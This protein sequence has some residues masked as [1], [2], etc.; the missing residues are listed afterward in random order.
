MLQQCCK[1]FDWSAGL[2]PT[3][4]GEKKVPRLEYN[5]TNCDCRDGWVVHGHTCYHF[6]H[7]TENWID[8]K[9]VCQALQGS[10]VVIES[11]EENDFLQ[12]QIQ[13]LN[14]DWYWTALSDLEE[15]HNWGW[16]GDRKT[17]LV[18]YTNWDHGEPSSSNQE[19]CGAIKTNGRWKDITCHQF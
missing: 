13:S 14:H 9:L 6:S 19:N 12:N 4:A 5:K 18:Y 17:A 1:A 7:D 3:F 15:E 2:Q 16:M 8:A 10:L 11:Q